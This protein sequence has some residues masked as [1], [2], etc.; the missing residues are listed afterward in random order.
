MHTTSCLSSCVW[1]VIMSSLHLE[2][3]QVKLYGVA[4]CISCL[5]VSSLHAR[6]QEGHRTHSTD[7][8]G[9]CCC[10]I[11]CCALCGIAQPCCLNTNTAPQKTH[12]AEILVGRA[13]GNIHL[14]DLEPLILCKSLTST[15]YIHL[16]LQVCVSLQEKHCT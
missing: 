13:P 12:S 16:C 15:S 5:A 6:Q 2:T 14:V 8:S 1:L 3:R 10:N 4:P 7:V 11:T 9:I